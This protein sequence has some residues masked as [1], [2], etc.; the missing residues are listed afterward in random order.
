L[1]LNKDKLF[2][3][4]L[5]I[6]GVGI[7][8]PKHAARYCPKIAPSLIC[9][10]P[11]EGSDSAHRTYGLRDASGNQLL[12]PE[13]GKKL[14]KTVLKG[15][16]GGIPSGNV[17]MMPGTFIV[18]PQGKIIFAYYSKNITDHPQIEELVAIVNK[19]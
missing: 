7:G 12:D 19:N 15:N 14:V 13:V 18:N 11:E 16:F 1:E 5:Q 9:L 3:E 17:Q 6:V 10:V 2:N 8:E 4:G